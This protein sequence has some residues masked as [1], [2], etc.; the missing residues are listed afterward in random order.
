MLNILSSRLLRTTLNSGQT[1]SMSLPEVFT[2]LMR[3]EVATFEELRP[4]Q[5]HAW[6][7]FVVQL[8]VI[9]LNHG[10][11]DEPPYDS[12]MWAALLRGLTEEHHPDDEPWQLIVDDV[13]KPAFM[14]PPMS[15]PGRS[16]DYKAVVDT[17]DQ[18][19]MLVTS[20]GHDLKP[21]VAMEP[22]PDDWLFAL[23]TLQTMEGFSG[24]RNYGVSRMN[25]GLGNRPAFS[26]APAQGGVGAHVQRDILALLEHRPTLIRDGPMIEGGLS[27][28]WT[29]PWDG[30]RPEALLPNQLDPYFIEVCRRVR[31][32]SS[33]AHGMDAV[34]ATSRAARIEAKAMKGRMRD[35]WVP[36]DLKGSKS[37]TLAKGGFTYRRMVPYLASGD[38]AR[39]ALL[40]PA[41]S[42]DRFPGTMNLVARAMVR[43][44]G[45]TEGYYERVIPVRTK[46]RSAMI[47]RELTDELGQIAQD[48]I[49]DVAE[50]QRILSHAI[51]V[52]AARGEGDK[53]SAEHRNLAR[54][55][56]NR[57]DEVVDDGFFDQLQHQ[58]EAENED[59]DLIRKNWLINR[60]DGVFEHAR[61]TLDAALEALPCPVSQRY[62]AQA[63]SR[64]LFARRL[65]TS[66]RLQSVSDRVVGGARHD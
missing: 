39:P 41:P 21:A 29:V 31:L 33:D 3:Q 50:V 1:V 55:W 53:V 12:G 5:R 44:Q 9:A 51:Q 11:I 8:G 36:V 27:L 61:R 37:L 19:D 18:M 22:Q 23:I 66:Q 6:H 58:F 48:M 25:G 46:M 20:K 32:R 34:R 28:L 62:R 2:S 38:W 57:L 26:L 63:A 35:P 13:T 42:D 52:Y 30:T 24:A 65:A 16:I 59:R 17:P 4:H 45:K 15:S 49:D 54:P 56:L 7:A 14:Q 43:G 10:G 60:T 40:E 47:R 64:V